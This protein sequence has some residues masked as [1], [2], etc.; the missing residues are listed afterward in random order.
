MEA[1]NG[2]KIFEK[3]MTEEDIESGLILEEDHFP[4]FDNPKVEFV[5]FSVMDEDQMVWGFRCFTACKVGDEIKPVVFGE[6]TDFVNCHELR[7]KDK[8]IF[9]DNDND[10]EEGVP[11]VIHVRRTIELF[12]VDITQLFEKKLTEVDIQSGLVLDEESVIYPPDF[13]NIEDKHIEFT[14]MD[15]DR[16]VWNFRCFTT[17][18]VGGIATKPVV[19]GGW[20]EFVRHHGLKVKD[21]IIFYDNQGDSNGVPFVIHVRR[22]IRLFGVDITQ[23][24]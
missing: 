7:V 12:G 17:R 14:V 19:F 8:I 10:V 11:F 2:A 15:E 9:Y 22:T 16:M 4:N 18:M 5:D 20:G 6:W 13:N 1:A 24:D 21:K 23:V 3:K